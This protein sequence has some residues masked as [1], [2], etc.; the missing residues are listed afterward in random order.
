MLYNILKEKIERKV[1]KDGKIQDYNYPSDNFFLLVFFHVPSHLK[2][3]KS[4][5]D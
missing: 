3:M 1:S 5:K 4:V 2:I